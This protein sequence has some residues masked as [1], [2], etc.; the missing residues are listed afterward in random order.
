LCIA[1]TQAQQV[2]DAKANGA[3]VLVGGGAVP[4]KG[5]FFP[6]TVLT[7]VDH[8]MRVMQDESFG[9]VVGP[10]LTLTLTLTLTLRV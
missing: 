3:T 5:W 2:A 4:A 6:P 9:P 10:L 7:D 1:V 8:S